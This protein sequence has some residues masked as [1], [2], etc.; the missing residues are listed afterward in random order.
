MVNNFFINLYPNS[1]NNNN[2]RYMCNSNN[3]SSNRKTF[4]FYLIWL[5]MVNKL[6]VNLK[7]CWKI[8]VVHNPNLIEKRIQ[9]QK[10][11]KSKRNLKKI[12]L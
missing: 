5:L 1:N 10:K 4:L 11:K 8:L 9:I 2:N 3:N 6:M 7:I 12:N